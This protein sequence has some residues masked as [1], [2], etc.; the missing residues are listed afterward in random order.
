MRNKIIDNSAQNNLVVHKSGNEDITGN[1]N[2]TKGLTTQGD[3]QRT[4]NIDISTTPDSNTYIVPFAV[5]NGDESL[6]A[7]QQI[8]Y[9]PN[10]TLQN[11]IGL[12]RNINGTNIFNTI[13]LGIDSAGNRTAY[14]TTPEA[15]SNGL[16]IATTAWVNTFCKTTN[17]IVTEWSGNNA[18]SWYR[19]WSNGFIEQGGII[20][21]TISG[22]NYT[23]SKTF[24]KPFTSIPCLTVN[25]LSTQGNGY[26]SM[27][28]LSATAFSFATLSAGNN[29]QANSNGVAWYACGF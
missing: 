15:T 28:S 17:K 4:I 14:I 7:Y 10:G 1:K 29:Y 27:R 2:F 24:Y 26:N 6:K 3:I 11:T 16:N 8:A 5:N 21:G 19:K 12:R 13:D 20:T 25:F 23:V 18:N 9:Y 22:N